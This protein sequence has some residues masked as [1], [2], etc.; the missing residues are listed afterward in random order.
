M[1]CRLHLYP[2]SHSDKPFLMCV[3]LLVVQKG[4]SDLNTMVHHFASNHFVSFAHACG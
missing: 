2:T 3:F 1:A 4:Q